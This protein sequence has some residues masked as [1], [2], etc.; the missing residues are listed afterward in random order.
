MDFVNKNGIRITV[1]R[2][3]CINYVRRELTWIKVNVL[4]KNLLPSMKYL[5]WTERLNINVKLQHTAILY[6][7]TVQ[8]IY[9]IRVRK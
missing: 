2:K 5:K 3:C 1:K 9:I 7:P 4:K 6:V 8:F